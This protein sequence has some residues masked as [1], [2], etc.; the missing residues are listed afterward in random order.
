MRTLRVV[1]P[2]VLA[3][4]CTIPDKYPAL[5]ESVRT[6]ATDDVVVGAARIRDGV[7]MQHGALFNGLT[8]L[9]GRYELALPPGVIPN[10]TAPTCTCTTETGAALCDIGS[11][12][13]E[14]RV[15]ETDVDVI[16][17]GRTQPTMEVAEHLV[18]TRDVSPTTVATAHVA[19]DGTVSS[20][21]GWVRSAT[22][23]GQA[24]DLVLEPVFAV[25]PMCTCTWTG[26][27]DDECVLG[28]V[29]MTALQ[30]ANTSAGGVGVD[31]HCVGP[32][33][34]GAPEAVI[35]PAGGGTVIASGSI[36]SDNAIS[37]QDGDW[38]ALVTG[39]D[40]DHTI[41]YRTGTFAGTPRCTCTSIGAGGC[42][43]ASVD[44]TEVHVRVTNRGGGLAANAFMITCVGPR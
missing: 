2:A 40:G 18:I 32:S 39:A 38:M 20:D 25:P 27:L 22:P 26:D 35:S 19:A 10:T 8:P 15:T 6:T 1:A 23:T 14:V 42:T 41:R 13:Q 31:I 4:A 24:F 37:W 34:D 12:Y 28:D 7:L 9:A 5:S 11:S 44:E 16:C 17:F 33:P 30:V 43:L 21:G 3:A 36:Q 29:S